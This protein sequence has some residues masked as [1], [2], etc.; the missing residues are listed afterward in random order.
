MSANRV[1]DA[2]ADSAREFFSLVNA[3]ALD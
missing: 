3:L 1:R 2:V